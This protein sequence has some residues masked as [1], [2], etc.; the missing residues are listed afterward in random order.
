MIAKKWGLL[1]EIYF[2]IADKK[3]NDIS[4]LLFL[5]YFHKDTIFMGE[6]EEVICKQQQA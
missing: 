5:A 1:A 4:P 6:K 2:Y 3:S